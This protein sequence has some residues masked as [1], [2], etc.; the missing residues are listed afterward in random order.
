[1]REL[2]TLDAG[3][4]YTALAYGNGNEKTPLHHSEFM[5][6]VTLTVDEHTAELFLEKQIHVA[7]EFE[8]KRFLLFAE[9]LNHPLTVALNGITVGTLGQGGKEI[10]DLSYAIET[11]ATNHLTLTYIPKETTPLML[12]GIQMLALSPCH[13]SPWGIVCGT[14]VQKEEG[15]TLTLMTQVENHTS[16]VSHCRLVH[17]VLDE[18]GNRLAQTTTAVH[19]LPYEKT[20][21]TKTANLLS[22]T[23]WSES[24][25]VAYR[26]ETEL[27]ENNILLDT[28]E[29]LIGL[30]PVKVDARRGILEQNVPKKLH[31]IE[32]LPVPQT[33][34]TPMSL[35]WGEA[36]KLLASG[37]NTVALT[38]DQNTETRLSIFDKIGIS[39]IL[40][41]PLSSL[42]Q[43]DFE[44]I[45]GIVS[46]LRS[47]PS[48]LLW[49]LSDLPFP[50]SDPRSIALFERVAQLLY[51]EDPARPLTALV[52]ESADPRILGL[53]SVL[54]V[55]G[56][57]DITF[58]ATH[59]HKPVLLQ[60][61][62]EQS[63]LS[64]FH[65]MSKSHFVGHIQKVD[66]G[67]DEAAPCESSIFRLSMYAPRVM[68]Q[69]RA[70]YQERF[71]VLDLQLG[72]ID[73]DTQS[74]TLLTNCENT[75]LWVDGRPYGGTVKTQSPD[76]TVQISPNFG[77][78]EAVGFRFGREVARV[79]I[80]PV[81]NPYA[82]SLFPAF[83]PEEQNEGDILWVNCSVL[84]SE[85]REVPGV[86]EK[87]SFT[88]RGGACFDAY[89]HLP[90]GESI[91]V[92]LTDGRVAV[93]LRRTEPRNPISLEVFSD[94]YVSTSLLLK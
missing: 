59:T 26:V 12:V 39:A 83:V 23:L 72:Q 50:L 73:G 29:T 48:I 20:K 90:K 82:L 77:Y 36:Q 42:Y 91:T 35:L 92:S 89:P 5:L 15:Y 64:A 60:T 94:L 47:H 63:F 18:E 40:S 2:W 49:S 93:A 34:M 65:A 58:A 61:A 69:M 70:C 51:A 32:N 30:R 8:G 19:I 14:E 33:R 80:E 56:T 54:T 7:K 85:G 78:A 25:P 45:K 55:S 71:D 44:G 10:L 3:W 4:S 1:M 43:G 21:S 76:R 27:Y 6:P 22:A 86:C 16:A 79:Q 46:R 37:I 81:G 66:L 9:G 41:L 87:V 62:E 57:E 74:L 53:L 67:I 17:T 68:A 84:D 38:Y 52:D 31:G 88:L 28:T 13:I 24:T 75:S 11:D